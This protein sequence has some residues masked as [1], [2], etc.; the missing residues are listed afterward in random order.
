VCQAETLVPL[1][2]HDLVAGLRQLA[3]GTDAALIDQTATEILTRVPSDTPQY[4]AQ[5]NRLAAS[6]AASLLDATAP[7]RLF[8]SYAS[9]DDAALNSVLD[10]LEPLRKQSLVQPWSIRDLPAG[11]EWR[12]EIAKQLSLA[13]IVLLVGTKN[14]VRLKQWDSL[15]MPQLV[16]RQSRDELRLLTVR[17]DEDVDT[18]RLDPALPIVDLTDLS[19]AVTTA[20]DAIRRRRVQ[21]TGGGR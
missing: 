15:N 6:Y 11:V 19:K 12:S 4:N 5:L 17:V 21:R 8:I 3:P 18:H 20:V 1:S 14:Y 10:A 13:E 7:V 16:A 9:Q 2:R